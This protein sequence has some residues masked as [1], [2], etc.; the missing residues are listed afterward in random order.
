[1]QALYAEYARE[2]GVISAPDD[3]DVFRALTRD[4]ERNR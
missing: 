2:Y 1:M 4:P 3:F